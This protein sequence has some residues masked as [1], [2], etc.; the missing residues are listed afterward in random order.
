MFTEE[1]TSDQCGHNYLQVEPQGSPGYFIINTASEDCG[2]HLNPGPN[3]QVRYHHLFRK[4]K[5]AKFLPLYEFKSS[6]FSLFVGHGRLQQGG[7]VLRG[8][9]S[10][11][12]HTFIAPNNN[13]LQYAIAF[14][15]G[16]GSKADNGTKSIRRNVLDIFSV[17]Y[18]QEVEEDK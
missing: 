13:P 14:A 17:Q 12:Y 4:N 7:C 1:D 5:C 18:D 10:L 16:A 8:K 3:H 2:L 11:R 15:Y 6:P 9:H